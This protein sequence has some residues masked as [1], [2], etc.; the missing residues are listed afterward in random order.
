MGVFFET[1]PFDKKSGVPD[2]RYPKRK[3]GCPRHYS[4]INEKIVNP[5]GIIA[6]IRYNISMESD[7]NPENKI[8]FYFKEFWPIVVFIGTIIVGWTNINGE[9]RYQEARISALEVR[10]N[11]TDTTLAKMASDVAYIRG[12]LEGK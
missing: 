3:G 10:S 8:F 4:Y 11:A 7:K 12:K 6:R 9:L 2:E 1:R 5:Q